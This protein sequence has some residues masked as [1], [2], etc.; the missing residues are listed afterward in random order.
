MLFRSVIG[1]IARIIFRMKWEGTESLPDK[2]QRLIVVCNHTT[3]FDPIALAM[4]VPS[5]ISFLAKS[6]LFDHPLGWFVKGLGAIAIDRGK[7]D[8]DALEIFAKR[9]NSAWWLGVFP[10]GTRHRD[11]VLGKP[12]SGMSIVAKMTESDVLPCAIIYDGR[13]RFGCHV[14]VRYGNVIPYSKLGLEDNTTRA[15]KSAT[16]LI[17][18]EVKRLRGEFAP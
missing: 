7:G 6:E 17:W 15:L 12:K 2:K 11:G 13:L 18:D 8:K 3:Y 1:L 4:G 14:T 10:E 5:R 9:S 16:N